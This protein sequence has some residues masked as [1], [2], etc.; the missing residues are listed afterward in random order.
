MQ[1]CIKLF[2]KM[3]YKKQIKCKLTNYNVKWKNRPRNNMEWLRF[4]VRSPIYFHYVISNNFRRV[5][6]VLLYRI[7][8]NHTQGGF[9]RL[10]Y[11]LATSDSERIAIDHVSKKLDSASTTKK[12]QL[13]S[14]KTAC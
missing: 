8:R 13:S 12:S 1:K 6:K 4:R 11:T 2:A 3:Y 9:I 14:N 7:V 5:I 10:D